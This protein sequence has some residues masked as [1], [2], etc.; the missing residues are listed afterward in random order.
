MDP[1]A[2]VRSDLEIM[3][4]V[5][6]RLG[7]GHYFSTDPR[8]VFDELRRA[9]AGGIADYS[10]IT[11]E[12][13]DA[14]QGVFW[15]CP[16]PDHPG[17]PRL[18][19][20]SFPTVDGHAR[21][22]RV[23]H[24]SPGETPSRR[25]PYV[26]ITGRLMG[27]YQS[28]TQTRRHPTPEQARLQP[29]AELHPDLARQLDIAHAD[30]VQLRTPRGVANFRARVTDEIRPDTVFVPFHWGGASNANALTNPALDPLSK[31]P[32]FKACAVEV[33]RIGSPEDSHL[34]GD[35]P[36]Q[37]LGAAPDQ[38]LE[39][40]ALP[41]ST[42]PSPSTRRRAASMI[43]ENRFLQGFYPFTGAGLDVLAPIHSDLTR[44]VPDG[45]VNQTL[46]F[47]GGNSSPELITVVLLRDG[48]PM[49]Y[50]PIGAKSDVNVPLRVVEDIEGGSV[51]ELQLS[52][53]LGCS[54]TVVVDLG[55]VEH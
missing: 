11:Y 4:A 8:E 53:P 48:L 36:V 13:I 54:G 49:R 45:V 50:F 15:P 41:S 38:I 30:I 55:M 1:P 9:S 12:R 17:T 39:T 21:F 20:E 10:G 46:Y 3:K 37:G 18:F 44:Q 7:R 2:G 51:I 22:I 25:F 31:M 40:P 34:L 27:Q 32:E 42:R 16:A 35:D 52:A 33:T 24:K 26:L 43:S 19:T 14:E 28:G 5:A 29:E 47:R 23:T 6:D